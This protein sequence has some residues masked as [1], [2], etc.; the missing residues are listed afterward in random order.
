MRTYTIGKELKMYRFKKGCWRIKEQ[1]LSSPGFGEWVRAGRVVWKACISSYWNKAAGEAGAPLWL[2]SLWVCLKHLIVGPV[3]QQSWQSGG[4]S[5]YTMDTQV[6]DQTGIH[7]RLCIHLSWPLSY[8]DIQSMM[9]S[10][11]LPKAHVTSLCLLQIQNYTGK[12]ILKSITSSL[13]L[14]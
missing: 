10:L 9:A 4:R 12:G 13:N 5:R 11:S 6:Q 2:P 3:G 8:S 7:L 1:S 14:P